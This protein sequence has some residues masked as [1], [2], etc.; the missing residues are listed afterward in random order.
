M[1]QI[2]ICGVREIA[3]VEAVSQ[4][5]ADAIGWNFFPPSCRFLD[6][7]NAAQR[8]AVSLSAKHAAVGVDL[9]NG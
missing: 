4:S 8:E 3:D 1:F 6:P 5:G 7:E 9:L 2:K